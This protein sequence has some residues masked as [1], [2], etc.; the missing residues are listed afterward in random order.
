M[1]KKQI[2]KKILMFPLTRII[3]GLLVVLG[4]YISFQML[5]DKAFSLFVSSRELKNLLVSAI[6]SGMTIAAYIFLFRF[7]EKR[8]VSEFVFQGQGKNLALGLLVGFSLQ[9]L[10]ILVIYLLGGYRVLQV[11]KLL[12]LIP[13]LSMSITSSIFEEIMFRG[14]IFRLVEEKLGS[15]MALAVSALIFGLLHMVNPNSSLLAALAIAV[16]AGLLLGVAYMYTRNLWFPIGIH[17]AWNFTQGGIFGAAV[18][19][20]AMRQS[21][22]SPEISG[23]NWFTGGEF[24]PE[25]SVQTVVFCLVLAA[26][27]F[28]KLYR[29]KRLVLP[30]W[31]QS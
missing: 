21:L 26:L 30:F 20:N 28:A 13:A 6:A 1:D 17:F 8:R 29:E 24:G 22:L 23:A 4:A 5:S 7:Y 19:G 9:A 18:S 27:L 31:K 16:E 10:T 25:N 2:A 11:N 12:Y 14:V 3:I 15:Y